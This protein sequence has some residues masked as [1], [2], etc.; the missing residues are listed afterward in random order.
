MRRYSPDLGDASAAGAD[1]AP[2][3]TPPKLAA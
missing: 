3:D 2:I 1:M